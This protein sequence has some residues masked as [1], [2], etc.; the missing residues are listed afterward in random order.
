MKLTYL[1]LALLLFIL[2]PGC[3]QSSNA[4]LNP[5][6]ISLDT[7]TIIQNIDTPWELT[8][9]PDN[10][11]WFTERAG[12]VNRAN[13]ENGTNTVVLTILEVYEKGESGLLGM[14]LHP[15]F[16][17]TPY[18][19]LVYTYLDSPMIREKL[20]RYTWNGTTLSQP[21]VLL[22]E[23]PANSYH[24]GSRLAFGP[25]G[26]LYMSTGD[27][28]YMPNSQNLNVLA[29]KILRMNDDGSIPEDNPIPGSYI[30][31]WGLRNSQGLVF[32]PQGILYGSEHG[33]DS[34]D[35]INIL[36]VNRNYGWPEVAGFCD[37]PAEQEFCTANNVKEPIYAWTPTLA[38]AG[39]DY[40]H[41]AAIPEWQNSL[42]MTSLK[43]STLY[44]L[45]LNEAGTAVTEVTPHFKAVWGRLRDVC[46][47]PAGDV[48][49]AVSNRDGRGTPKPGD[50]RIVKLSATGTTG[51]NKP[52]PQ[53]KSMLIYPNP[54]SGDRTLTVNSSFVGEEYQIVSSN[55]VLIKNGIVSPSANIML[56]HSLQKG[57]YLLRILGNN[58][59][60]NGRFLVL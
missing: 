7:T 40:Y 8:W 43:A 20:V 60:A 27:A 15:D 24:D 39:I 53:K 38:V 49:L 51:L 42:L 31:A 14:A 19:Y 10:R 30:W 57:L 32:S 33:P 56:E 47:S 36:E 41:Q 4:P 26:K 50:D 21:E 13:P 25:D 52:D 22:T 48:Y 2:F 3:S 17:A 18:V 44:S 29:G 28:G 45:K 46:I 5:G 34:D 55:G 6:S 9:G 11:L 58:F 16:E 37:T 1:A 54:V 23:I 59:P 35:E 12:R